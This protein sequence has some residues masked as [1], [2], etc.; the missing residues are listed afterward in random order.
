VYKENKKN[1]NVTIENLKARAENG[2]LLSIS[3]LVV[4][5][6][7]DHNRTNIK[8]NILIIIFYK[9]INSVKSNKSTPKMNYLLI[10][11]D[12]QIT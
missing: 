3:G 1:P 8:G 12:L 9:L 5:K 7:E 2:S 4:I 6:A 11:L 10:E